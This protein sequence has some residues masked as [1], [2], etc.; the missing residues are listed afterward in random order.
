LEVT[1]VLKVYTIVY[2]YNQDYSSKSENT[3]T[4]V[5]LFHMKQF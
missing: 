2:I 3:P 1:K 5:F 4:G